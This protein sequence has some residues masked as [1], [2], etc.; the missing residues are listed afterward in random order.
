MNK[1]QLPWMKSNEQVGLGDLVQQ[2]VDPN[3]RYIGCARCRQRQ[4]MLNSLL[5]F[6]GTQQQPPTRQNVPI[7][8]P[9]DW[10]QMYGAV[11]D[12]SMPDGG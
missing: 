2:F 1:I 8:R 6:T 11:D 5:T 4:Q 7:E 3:H 9:T 10:R 12:E